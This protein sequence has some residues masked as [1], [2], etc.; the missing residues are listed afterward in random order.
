[1]F[2]FREI[3][4]IREYLLELNCSYYNC[5]LMEWKF[6]YKGGEGG[7]RFGVLVYREY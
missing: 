4:V 2:N 3:L 7:G 6:R 5:F 1:M